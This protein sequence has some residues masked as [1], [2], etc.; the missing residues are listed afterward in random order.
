MNFVGVWGGGGSVCNCVALS[1][2]L[3]VESCRG[4]LVCDCVALSGD[5]PVES[6][7]GGLVC[8]C[9]ALSG[10]L[11]VESCRGSLC[12]TVWPSFCIP[13]GKECLSSTSFR[14]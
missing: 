10:D 4:G 6:C 12:V 11:P 7:R 13:A 3:P 9:V 2:D 14:H 8:D 5:L 1:G